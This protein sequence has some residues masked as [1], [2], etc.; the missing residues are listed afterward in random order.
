VACGVGGPV[1]A[2]LVNPPGCSTVWTLFSVLLGQYGYTNGVN[3]A[4]HRVRLRRYGARRCLHSRDGRRS[5]RLSKRQVAGVEPTRSA[6]DSLLLGT[7]PRRSGHRRRRADE[8]R[9]AYPMIAIVIGALLV[10]VGRWPLAAQR[11]PRPESRCGGSGPRDRPPRRTDPHLPHRASRSWT[12]RGPVGQPA[13]MGTAETYSFEIIWI[14]CPEERHGPRGQGV[15]C[16]CPMTESNW[17]LVWL[18]VPGRA[19]STMR[20]CARFSAY[21][22]SQSTS[23]RPSSGWTTVLWSS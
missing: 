14:Q 2:C 22:T 10:T 18:S 15:S 1:A 7:G 11:P 20:V 16:W 12:D 6:A 5:R 8:A 4:S 21:R 3:G 9:T 19:V 17:S 23:M 13:A